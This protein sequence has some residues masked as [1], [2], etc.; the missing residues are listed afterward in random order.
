[1]SPGSKLPGRLTGL[2]PPRGLHRGRHKYRFRLSIR[3]GPCSPCCRTPRNGK[4]LGTGLRLHSRQLRREHLPPLGLLHRCTRNLCAPLNSAS[5][6]PPGLLRRSQ[7]PPRD[8]PVRRPRCS[9]RR[10]ELLL[11]SLLHNRRCHLLRVFSRLRVQ[12][13]R[14]SPLFRRRLM[15]NCQL[16]GNS[17]GSHHISHMRLLRDSRRVCS[18][19]HPTS[20]LPHHRPYLHSSDLFSNPSRIRTQYRC[21]GRR[22]G[23]RLSSSRSSFLRILP[24][25]LHLRFKPR[26]GPQPSWRVARDPTGSNHYF[27]PQQRAAFLSSNLLIILST[28]VTLLQPLGSLFR[29]TLPRLHRHVQPRGNLVLYGAQ[30][31]RQLPRRQLPLRAD[32]AQPSLP[33]PSSGHSLQICKPHTP[34]SPLRRV[35]PLRPPPIQIRPSAMRLRISPLDRRLLSASNHGCPLLQHL[36]RLLGSVRPLPLLGHLPR[37]FLRGWPEAAVQSGYRRRLLRLRS[38]GSSFAWGTM[39]SRV[40]RMNRQARSCALRHLQLP[41]I[42]IGEMRQPKRRSPSPA[43]FR[44]EP[45]VCPYRFHLLAHRPNRD[46]T[47]P[48]Q[49]RLESRTR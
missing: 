32:P 16:K 13:G 14:G 30:G 44:R 42:L 23:R 8:R 46:P 38:Q 33:L 41:R 34:S 48:S 40:Q 19:T 1:M 9:R 45:R 17:S 37:F 6:R 20:S 7:E 25:S 28:R 31:S 35:F 36:L 43:G 47:Q 24:A 3:C 27:P 22:T 26:P 10:Q 12:R 39:T 11:F 49:S 21:R 29:S 18:S 15:L 4:T 5:K 2:G